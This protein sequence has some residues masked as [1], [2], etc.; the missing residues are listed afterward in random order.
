MNP[1][2]LTII[3]NNEFLHPQSSYCSESYVHSMVYDGLQQE[4]LKREEL[5]TKWY[6]L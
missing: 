4:Q 2:T 5:S 1:E 3:L 6:S